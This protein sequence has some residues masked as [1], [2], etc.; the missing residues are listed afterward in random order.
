MCAS[1][2]DQFMVLADVA[3]LDSDI[4]SAVQCTFELFVNTNLVGIFSW[5]KYEAYACYDIWTIYVA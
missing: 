1:Q 2:L 5:K 3:K 4:R